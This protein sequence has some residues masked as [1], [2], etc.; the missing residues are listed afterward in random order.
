MVSLVCRAVSLT[1]LLAS[2]RRTATGNGK[3]AA[4]GGNPTEVVAAPAASYNEQD[5]LAIKPAQDSGGNDSIPYVRGLIRESGTMYQLLI[6]LLIATQLLAGS[7]QTVYLCVSLDGTY[8][9]VDDGP[10]ACH[11]TAEVVV[12][13]TTGFSCCTSHVVCCPPTITDKLC[14][15]SQSAADALGAQSHGCTHIPLELSS[16]D[17]ATLSRLDA[18]QHGQPLLAIAVYSPPVWDLP[19]LPSPP[20]VGRGQTDPP[21]PSYS[22][23][24]VSTVVF[25]C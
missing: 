17:P 22:V 21:L 13:A 11:C 20:R 8:C 23:A 18:D 24:V 19:V 5:W 7:G 12:P 10:N 25:R 15:D 14:L 2:I 1:A 16:T 9:C 3:T 6:Q 4:W